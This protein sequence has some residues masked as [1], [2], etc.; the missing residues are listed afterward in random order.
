MAL[1]TFYYSDRAPTTSADTLITS[2]SRAYGS[3][4]TLISVDI[5]DTVTSIGSFAFQACTGLTTISIP[6]NVTSLGSSAFQQCTNLISASIGSGVS[7][8]N[9]PGTLFNFCI[10]LTSLTVDSANVNFASQNNVLCNK[11]LNTILMFPGGI[12]GTFSIPSNITNISNFAFFRAKITQVL[13]P[14]S[15]TT[16]SSDAFNRSFL[17]S[18][19][20]PSTVTNLGDWI[21]FLCPE[22][23]T[24]TVNA[25]RI[26]Y[27]SFR[28][29]PKL[30]NVNINGSPPRFEGFAFNGCE[31][32]TNIDIPLSVTE[33]RE[34][35]FED[36]VNLKSIVIPK[37][38]TSIFSSCFRDCSTLG[39]VIFLGNA[40]TFG[41]N[42]FLNTAAKLK[43]YRQN[44][45]AGWTSTFGGKPVFILSSNIIKGGGTGK[46]T[47][48]KRN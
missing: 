32:L 10:N 13:I 29:C 40:P 4:T 42:V 19:T 8:I 38:V 21:C 46:L 39:R 25:S 47:T 11:A 41:S 18:I 15:V 22:L 33:I 37:N 5:G 17:T 12:T 2:S 26:G 34:N 45:T 3:T 20:I 48:K 1:T 44:L 16:I 31:S 35:V 14:S 36:C 7:T 27:S 28:F 43:I 24:A 9:S 23:I 30:T 6:N